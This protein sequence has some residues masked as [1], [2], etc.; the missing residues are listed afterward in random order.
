MNGI[1][2]VSK[3]GIKK[4]DSKITLKISIWIRFVSV[5]SLVNCNSH[6]IDKNIKKTSVQDFK[7]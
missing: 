3:F 5:N 6:E 7:I 2:T 1:I 4:V